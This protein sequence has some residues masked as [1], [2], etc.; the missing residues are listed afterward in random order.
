MLKKDAFD[1]AGGKAGHQQA[2]SAFGSSAG[3][4]FGSRLENYTLG[5]LLYTGS[6]SQVNA[7]CTSRGDVVCVKTYRKAALS[8]TDMQKIKREM[9]IFTDVT[10]PNIVRGLASFTTSDGIHLIQEYAVRGDLCDVAAL[11]H[12]K[13]LNE[14]AVAQKI[15]RPIM[16]A[17]Q[18]LHGRKIIHR[19]LKPENI[20][21]TREGVTKICDF[22]LA[23][24]AN[25]EPPISRV[26][27]PQ[28][29][30]PEIVRLPRC[31]DAAAK[32]QL[33]AAG[34]PRYTNLVDIWSAGCVVFEML[35]GYT[36]F[37]GDSV[38]AI[39]DKILAFDPSR[40]GAFPA[41]SRAGDPI[42]EDA[43]LF[44]EACLQTDPAER[45]SADTLLALSAAWIS[46]LNDKAGGSPAAAAA[47]A[48]APAARS[49]APPVSGPRTPGPRHLQRTAAPAA[50][51]GSFYAAAA[52]PG[53]PETAQQLPKSAPQPAGGRAIGASPR[54]GEPLA[55]AQHATSARVGGAVDGELR[56]LSGSISTPAVWRDV[57]FATMR[58]PLVVPS[59]AE[60]ASHVTAAAAPFRGHE[61]AASSAA[62]SIRGASAAMNR[63]CSADCRQDSSSAS[64][65]F[66][67][68]TSGGQEARAAPGPASRGCPASTDDASSSLRGA[69]RLPA[70]P[71]R[72]RSRP[73]RRPPADMFGTVCRSPDSDRRSSICAATPL[74]F[75]AA[76]GT[77]NLARSGRSGSGS[78]ILTR[79]FGNAPAASPG[80]PSDG[81]GGRSSNRSSWRRWGVSSVQSAFSSSSSGAPS[82]VGS[83]CKESFNSTASGM[84]NAARR[85]PDLEAIPRAGGD[86]DDEG[87]DAEDRANEEAAAQAA[88]EAAASSRAAPPAQTP[89]GAGKSKRRKGEKKRRGAVMTQLAKFLSGLSP[90]AGGAS[91]VA[92][93]AS[94]GGGRS[95]AAALGTE[96]GTRHVVRASAAA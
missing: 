55:I 86:F 62:S 31:T 85:L 15:A 72:I 65:H 63:D 61:S 80:G 68:G 50:D 36:L 48:P 14:A 52:L 18:Y 47:A 22:G 43:H 79:L 17:L 53:T 90:F 2:H 69:S 96:A 11:F 40:G 8:S 94:T 58:K 49:A 77:P 95:L 78:G 60:P 21:V 9:A 89:A 12:K 26:G 25:T 92:P 37:D 4:G 74:P 7:A 30:A 39:D 91:P 20:V 46:A 67:N 87:P 6:R 35:V 76:S 41:R 75:E 81:A 1:D 19:D 51:A 44:L 16:L 33:Y 29:M 42:S 13:C 73:A 56:L 64:P 57:P 82:Q 83:S 88:A 3:K 70:A 5:P 34:V 28:F 71:R 38:Q 84:R 93:E 23:I 24:D 59:P 45:A 10:H 32:A 27:T 66:A 54:A